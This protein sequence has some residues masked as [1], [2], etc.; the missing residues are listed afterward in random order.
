MRYRCWGNGHK[1]PGA[2][3]SPSG[4]PGRAT[5]KATI[6]EDATYAGTT[7]RKGSV[8]EVRENVI[9]D[10][11]IRRIVSYSLVDSATDST[12]DVPQIIISDWA[13]AGK[14]RFSY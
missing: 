3:M 2:V 7:L 10:E 8:F 12:V 4:N 6:L 14:I 9:R 11:T 1:M 5:R 13:L